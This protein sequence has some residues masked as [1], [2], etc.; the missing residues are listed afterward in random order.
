MLSFPVSENLITNAEEGWA[1]NS[2]GRSMT[3]RPDWYLG[4]RLGHV[5]Y[6]VSKVTAVIIKT[7]NITSP[8]TI[9]EQIDGLN[10][11]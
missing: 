1:L 11:K 10:F 2:K 9:F 3:S 6:L 4:C 5:N 7:V 8:V